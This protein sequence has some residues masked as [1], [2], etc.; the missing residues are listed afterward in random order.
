MFRRQD[1]VF[2]LPMN[3]N[4]TDYGP[5]SYTTTVNGATLTTNEAGTSNKA[6]DFD[7]VND[8][9]T[10]GA[11]AYDALIDA[12]NAGSVSLYFNMIN[13]Y[14]GA[15]NDIVFCALDDTLTTLYAQQISEG[16]TYHINY[17]GSFATSNNINSTTGSTNGSWKRTIYESTYATTKYNGRII[18]NGTVL[19]LAKSDTNQVISKS[20]YASRKITIGWRNGS[21]ANRSFKGKMNNVFAIKKVLTATE[22][23]YIA[24]FGNY[25]RLA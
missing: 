15:N 13:N 18:E 3:N 5:S 7:G 12:Y 17:L 11:S 23:S 9:I 4:A 20:V 6:Y 2:Y 16:S 8:T 19:T 24:Q 10:M 21:P 25:K 1:F 22:R 14:S